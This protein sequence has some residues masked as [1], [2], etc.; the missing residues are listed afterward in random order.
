MVVPFLGL[1]S[2]GRFRLEGEPVSCSLGNTGLC[3]GS[4]RVDGAVV[5]SGR[6]GQ[7]ASLSESLT[8]TGEDAQQWQGPELARE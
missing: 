7:G 2:R 4:L 6:G 5:L 1:G 3:F 8:D